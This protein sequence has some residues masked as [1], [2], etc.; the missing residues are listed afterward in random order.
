MKVGDVAKNM[1]SR[2]VVK[3]VFTTDFLEALVREGSDELTLR[4]EEEDVLRTFI[5]HYECGRQQMG[6]TVGVRD[7]ACHL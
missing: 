4:R 5:R 1:E 3:T 7:V 6:A 2:S